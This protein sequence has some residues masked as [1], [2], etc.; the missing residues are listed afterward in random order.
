M[1]KQKVAVAIY[2][3]RD[4]IISSPSERERTLAK[5][6]INEL[7][8]KYTDIL[9]PRVSQ[10]A[11]TLY[12]KNTKKLRP[13]LSDCVWKDRNRK[14]GPT[15]GIYIL[16]HIIPISVLIKNILEHG[17]TPKDIENILDIAETA[18]IIK[19]EDKKLNKSGLKSIMSTKPHDEYSLK[20]P[21]S[22]YDTVGIVLI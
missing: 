14:G 22:R 9:I 1:L 15:K 21:H 4:V 10:K 6:M 7:I 12:N 2:E 18:W 11:N 16:E 17:N 3:I 8:R 13:S 19:K 5:E 20:N